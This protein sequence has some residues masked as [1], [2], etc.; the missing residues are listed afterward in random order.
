MTHST[1]LTLAIAPGMRHEV[2]PYHLAAVDGLPRIHPSR[3]NGVLFA[4]GHGA[5]VTLP[6]SGLPAVGKLRRSQTPFLYDVPP[7]ESGASR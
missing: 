1:L 2:D 3:W 6:T 4:V 7:L 5:L